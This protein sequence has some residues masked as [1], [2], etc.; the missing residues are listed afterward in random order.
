MTTG[1]FAPLERVFRRGE[2]HL[3]LV[4]GRTH[5]GNEAPRFGGRRPPPRPGVCNSRNPVVTFAAA[6]L[7][8]D[9]FY[10]EAWRDRL[11]EAPATSGESAVVPTPDDIKTPPS[12]VP[13]L[14]SALLWL[15]P[16]LCSW[17]FSASTA[18]VAVACRCAARVVEAQLRPPF[19]QLGTTFTP[20]PLSRNAA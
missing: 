15:A 13:P 4:I 7:L 18:A 14:S 20:R 11:R 16:L 10:T 6:I 1:F 19:P 12:C 8:W 5:A 2:K 17:A 9:C 3:G